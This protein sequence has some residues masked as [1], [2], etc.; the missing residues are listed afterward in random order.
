MFLNSNKWWFLCLCRHMRPSL[1]SI[2]D[3]QPSSHSRFLTLNVH[4]P[5]G[6]RSRLKIK[7]KIHNLE[8]IGYDLDPKGPPKSQGHS[9]FPR[10]RMSLTIP[11][12]LILGPQGTQWPRVQRLGYAI[13]SWPF[14]LSDLGYWVTLCTQWP[15]VLVTLCTLWP[16]ILS[17]LRYSVTS[18]TQWP[19]GGPALTLGS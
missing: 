11:I 8:V 16:Q 9:S 4:E 10:V 18:G 7:A 3:K 19:N 5:E 17:D 15:Q 6:Q 12:P 13:M 1:L 2:L 14:V